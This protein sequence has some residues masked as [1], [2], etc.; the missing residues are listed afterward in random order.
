M[1]LLEGLDIFIDSFFLKGRQ[2][3]ENEG[4]GGGGRAI[5]PNYWGKG[6]K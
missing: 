1:V 5:Y 2:L 3:E 4:P 6:G